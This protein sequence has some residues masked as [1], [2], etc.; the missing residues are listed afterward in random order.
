MATTKTPISDAIY[1]NHLQTIE[2]LKREYSQRGQITSQ[3]NAALEA[4]AYEMTKELIERCFTY[5]RT[6]PNMPFFN[7]F[8][9]E[10]NSRNNMQSLTNGDPYAVGRGL[11]LEFMERRPKNNKEALLRNAIEATNTKYGIG[12]A[13]LGVQ[14][15][16][17]T[18]DYNHFTRRVNERYP[19]IN[20][21]RD[22]QQAVAPT[23]MA[24][25]FLKSIINE[26]EIQR[27]TENV[28]NA[29]Q[30]R[31]PEI[32]N[33]QVHQNATGLIR[34]E[35]PMWKFNKSKDVSIGKGLY[36]STDIGNVRPNQEDSVLIMYHPQNPDFKML[37]VSDGMGGLDNGEVA[38]SY[39][40]ECIQR[41]FNALPPQYFDKRNTEALKEGYEQAIKAISKS[42]HQRNQSSN[43]RGES[44]ATFCGAI[45]TEKETIISNVGDSRAY[46][47]SKG[48][49]TQETQDDSFVFDMYLKRSEGKTEAEK[50]QIKEEIRFNPYS[51][52]IKQAMG[53]KDEVEPKSTIIDN[54]SYDCLLLVSD[55]ISDCLSDERIK[56]ITKTTDRKV[57][58]RKLIEETKAR[59]S[60]N[61]IG[62][63]RIRAGKDNATVAL[64]DKSE[65]KKEHKI[66][67]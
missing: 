15:V 4:R 62:T 12:K 23:E 64:Y 9:R 35:D 61:K 13:C 41:W 36:A 17:L 25:I 63:G 30:Q 1:Y 22:L 44:G 43:V 51:N 45:V 47:Y 8:T 65:V 28:R 33:V 11:A 40:V 19:E 66:E 50:A 21:R 58:A 16:I 56:A 34:A 49:L 38:S 2:K 5:M 31:H 10:G 60:V 42:L 55:G 26:H 52:V 29:L 6:N 59:D 67:R 37:V 20:Y 24:D 3:I 53:L 54:S 18:G 57:L 46:T 32:T 7:L 14:E 39:V 27:D 48:K